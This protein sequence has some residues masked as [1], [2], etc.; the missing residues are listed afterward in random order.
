[1]FNNGILLLAVAT[2]GLI[3][4]FHGDTHALVPLFALGAFLA[5]TLSQTG[6]V[7]LWSRERGKS[8]LLKAS[9][10]AVGAIATAGTVIVV[11][12]TKFVS[13]A[14]I[15]VLLIPLIVI[16]LQ[17]IQSHYEAIAKELSLSEAPPDLSVPSRPRVVIPVAGVHRG[18]AGAIAFARSIS[19]D[20]TAVYVELEPGTAEEV[21]VRW[22][23]CWPD[24]PLVVVPS[25][26]RSVVG[27][28]LGFLDETDSQHND[29]QLAA[30]VL[31]EFVPA[32]W[33]QNILHAQTGWLI[34]AALHY[35][36]R[37]HGHQ[38]AIIDVPFHL[39][40]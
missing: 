10:N 8:W 29:G 38:R 28:L 34:R 22:E 21:R 14:W 5:F 32:T 2:G 4:L 13:G 1:V 3:V 9:L 23:H 16:A 35:R 7:V 30:V 37:R 12:A 11:G 27:P 18:I 17:R 33:W 24:V 26:Y 40:R 31:P 20:V 36:R 15:T 19:E 39:Q 6:M 25:P